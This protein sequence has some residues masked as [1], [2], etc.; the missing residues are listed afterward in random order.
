MLKQGTPTTPKYVDNKYLW[1]KPTQCCSSGSWNH[2]IFDESQKWSTGQVFK[3]K[4]VQTCTASNLYLI[5]Y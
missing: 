3:T 2:S 1:R 4:Q 5:S